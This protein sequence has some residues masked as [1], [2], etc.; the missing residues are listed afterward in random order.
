M[1]VRL[2]KKPAA[3]TDKN[4]G[5]PGGPFYFYGVSL[6]AEGASPK[7]IN[8]IGIDNENQ[9]ETIDC[10]GLQC[11]VTRISKD[12]AH[13]LEGRMEDL[14]WLAEASVL[15]QRAVAAIGATMDLLPARFG[16]VFLNEA[17]LEKHVASRTK[18][19][20]SAFKKVADA[21]E[22]GVKVFMTAPAGTPGAAFSAASGKDYL[23]QKA[24][25][26]AAQNS[27]RSAPDAETAKLEAA[28][29]K[30]SRAVAPTGKVSG[31]QPGLQWQASF[32]LPRARR[33]Q[34]DTVLRRFAQRW[35]D[36]KRIECTGPWPPY[37]FVE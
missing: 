16:T 21:E 32:L 7:K 13:A 26:L 17:S 31:A 22:W 24:K 12:F 27:R 19:L 29:T 10:A 6:R 34:W 23:R 15:H 9:V 8:A 28:L 20:H 1:A 30:L 35:G 2:K 25:A 14:E 37:S 33:K 36:A 3:G 5:R 11:W 4:A 18:A